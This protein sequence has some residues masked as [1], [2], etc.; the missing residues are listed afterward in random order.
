MWFRVLGCRAVG[1]QCQMKV[2]SYR[3]SFYGLGCR[4]GSIGLAFRAQS[5]LG[6]PCQRRSES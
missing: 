3:L 6:M 1:V 4:V 5:L 2:G